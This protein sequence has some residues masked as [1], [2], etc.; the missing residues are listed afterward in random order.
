MASPP[1]KSRNLAPFFFFFQ[2][3]LQEQRGCSHT[4]GAARLLGIIHPMVFL[5][6]THVFGGVVLNGKQKK[7]CLSCIFS[8]PAHTCKPPDAHTCAHTHTDTEFQEG[9]AGE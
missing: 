8:F 9:W 5:A 4:S 1:S 2:I 3:S 7:L 6:A